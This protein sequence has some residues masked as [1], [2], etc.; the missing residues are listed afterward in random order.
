MPDVFDSR[1]LKDGA[2]C[3]PTRIVEK[4]RNPVQPRKCHETPWWCS[5]TSWFGKASAR[6][7]EQISTRNSDRE[8]LSGYH[9]FILQKQ[10]RLSKGAMGTD[11][12]FNKQDKARPPSATVKDD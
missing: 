7:L 8:D 2:A 10:I 3:N 5:M 6:V 12:V 1:Q 4:T 9:S 11:F